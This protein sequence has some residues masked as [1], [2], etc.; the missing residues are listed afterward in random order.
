M[1]GEIVPVGDNDGSTL[2]DGFADSVVGRD[3][4]T[5]DAVKVG[6]EVGTI[7]GATDFEG[8]LDALSVG[9]A[10]GF[11]DWPAFVGTTE[12]VGRVDGM[13]EG[14]AD[15]TEEGSAEGATDAVTEGSAEGVSD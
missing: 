9:A 5:A 3:E 8:E 7:E 2:A 10:E 4:G 12:A 13:A 11:A 1:V 6:T 14:A 15:A